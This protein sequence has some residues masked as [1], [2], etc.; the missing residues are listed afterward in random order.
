MSDQNPLTPPSQPS[1]GFEPYQVP[2]YGDVAPD[3]PTQHAPSTPTAPLA[4]VSPATPTPPVAPIAPPAGAYG[5]APYPVS[6]APYP[7]GPAPY[8]IAPQYLSAPNH[9]LAVTSMVLGIVGLAG[10]VLTPVLGFSFILV[11]CSPFAIWLG[12]RSRK[13]IRREPQRYGGG[14]MATAG[15]ITGIVG[16]VLGILGVIAI[17]AIVIFFVCLFNGY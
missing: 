17:V 8:G 11:L 9:P 2:A 7:G 14:G 15:F 1:P 5:Q 6:P 13:E 3:A 12:A 10:L 16:V 4:S